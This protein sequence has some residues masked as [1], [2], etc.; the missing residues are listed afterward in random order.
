MKSW[1]RRHGLNLALVTGLALFG[2]LFTFWDHLPWNEPA[3]PEVIARVLEGEGRVR[4]SGQTEFAALGSGGV[5]VNQDAVWVPEGK[6]LTLEFYD[7]KKLVLGPRSLLFIKK[8]FRAPYTQDRTSLPFRVAAGKASAK[9]FKTEATHLEGLKLETPP[10]TP[11]SPLPVTEVSPV[12]PEA[13]PSGAPSAATSPL[14]EGIHPKPGA[15]LSFTSLGP[16]T[17]L[18][19]WPQSLNGTLELREKSASK[20]S[21]HTIQGSRF[22]RIPFEGLPGGKARIFTWTVI[23]SQGRIASGPH[24]LSI[25]PFSQEAVERLLDEPDS[26]KSLYIE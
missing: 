9:N 23:D 26:Q 22:L 4:S 6:S 5:L 1:M 18:F 25:Q 13:S 16:Q 10:V 24:E 11:A 17:L 12:A 20:I 15:T 7:G 21:R 19:A 14:P 3:A 8:P 2:S